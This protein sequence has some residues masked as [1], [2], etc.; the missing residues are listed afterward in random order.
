MR[1]GYEARAVLP[2]GA[3]T[4]FIMPENF[5]VAMDFASV[6]KVGSG[7]GTGNIMVLDQRRCPVGALRNLEHFFAQESC[8]WCTPC[9]D[10]L[11]WVERILA[12]IEEGEGEEEDL[13]TLA[14]QIGLLGPGS[15]FC[16][17]GSSAMGPLRSGLKFFRDV[18]EQH[19][20]EKRCPYHAGAE[21][22]A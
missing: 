16:D 22:W 8:G 2:G 17:L 15:T 6:P 1:E 20:R 11:P 21:S 7:L 3:S 4:A 19:I 14:R 12:A 10:G 5:D 9:R 18:F 13:D